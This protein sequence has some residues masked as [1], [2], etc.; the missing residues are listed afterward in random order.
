LRFLVAQSVLTAGIETAIPIT[1]RYIHATLPDRLNQDEL[2]KLLH[3]CKSDTTTIGVRNYAIILLLARLGL[4]AK[5][6]ILLRLEDVDWAKG[7]LFIRSSKGRER[8]LPLRK[9]VAECLLI[10]L[11]DCRPKTSHREIFITHSAP[12]RPMVRFAVPC[13][14]VRKLFSKAGIERRYG[15]AHLLRHTLASQ[16]INSGASFK[17]TADFLGHRFLQTTGIYAKLDLN[18]L[19]QIALPWPGGAK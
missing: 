2:G 13:Q 18:A 14:I 9:E 16:L 4:R 11:K 5:E 3:Q 19:S 12:Y 6:V 7:V 10:Y 17:D 15:K 1:K 8:M